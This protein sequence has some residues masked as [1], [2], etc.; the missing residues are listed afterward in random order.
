MDEY[1]NRIRELSVARGWSQAYLAQLVCCSKVQISGLE[2]G[3]PTLNVDWMRRIGAA[4]GVPPADLL[5]LSDNP[6]R[7]NRQERKLIRNTRAADPVQRELV[8]RAA[9]PLCM[10]TRNLPPLLTQPAARLG[11]PAVIEQA[12]G[13]YPDH[14]GDD[15][16]ARRHRRRRRQQVLPSARQGQAEHR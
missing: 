3:R 15:I 9:A 8:Y 2:R 6:L 12:D 16:R 13:Y 4:L 7:L 11:P 5:G 1:P 14:P 10:G